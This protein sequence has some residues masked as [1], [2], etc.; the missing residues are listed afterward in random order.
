MKLSEYQ[1]DTKL[2]GEIVFGGLVK[3]R[4]KKMKE[5][6]LNG[7]FELIQLDVHPTSLIS[8]PNGNLLCGTHGSVK[9][10]DEY[11]K[12][13]KSV[14]IG[15]F[16]TFC[17]LNYRNEIYVSVSEKHCILL[18][19]FNL[20]QLKQFDLLGLENNRCYRPFGLCCQGDYLY[21]CINGTSK[22]LIVT[23]DF[24]Y[25]NTI[26]LC[27]DL[28]Y[29][30]QT[31]ETTI[32]VSC[33]NVTLFYDLKTRAIKYE[34]NN[35]AT[36]N[37]N[38]IDSMFCASDYSKKKFYFFDSDGKFIEEM[39]MN[40]NLSN[41]ITYWAGGLCRHKDILYLADFTSKKLLKFIE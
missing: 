4:Y 9:L 12:E 14:L 17:A 11:F 37:I 24:E 10:L 27:G 19:D 15:G 26:Q 30:V 8:L 3:Y 31:S 16:F 23:L 21:I 36:S 38:Y 13:I 2:I 7:K 34:Y 35:Y 28:P 6:L 20:N 39:A 5:T 25:V 33:A 32:G 22:I 1:V 41:Y 40:E 18:F 29:R